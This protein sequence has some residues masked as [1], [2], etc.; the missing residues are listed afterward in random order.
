M[1]HHLAYVQNLKT[2]QPENR[3]RGQAGE[4]E[5][6]AQTSGERASHGDVCAARTVDGVTP[7]GDR[8]PWP[9]CSDHVVRNGN[10]TSLCGTSGIS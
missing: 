3:R 6:Q 1:P 8:G 2:K 10:V 4:G 7:Y 9:Y 5:S